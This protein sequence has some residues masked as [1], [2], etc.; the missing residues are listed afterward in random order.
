MASPARLE[1]VS[2][3]PRALPV[4][5]STRLT[6]WCEFIDGLQS[7]I[8]RNLAEALDQLGP[9]F[10]PGE[11]EALV[12]RALSALPGSQEKLADWKQFEKD[13]PVWELVREALK[14]EA[15]RRSPRPPAAVASPLRKALRALLFETNP[16]S[17]DEDSAEFLVAL[18]PPPRKRSV[19]MAFGTCLAQERSA[20][21]RNP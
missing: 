3:I 11:R 6:L 13:K 15:N 2:T 10:Q 20:A 9:D 8:R 12:E 16:D 5:R 1:R 21:R 18:G 17:V 19:F 7:D 14:N 4:S